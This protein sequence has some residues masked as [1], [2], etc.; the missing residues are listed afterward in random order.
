MLAELIELGYAA[1]NETGLY[2]PTLRMWELGTTTLADLPVKQVASDALAELHHRTGET[3]SL[4]VR[5]GDEALYIDKLISP[6]PMRFTTRVGSRVWLP[7]PAGGKAILAFSP[8]GDEVIERVAR[9][10]AAYD[11]DDVRRAMAH[12]R[13]HGYVSSS[14]RPGARSFA[15]PILDRARRPVGALSISAPTDRLQD[16]QADSIVD[17]V[18]A[19]ATRLSDS[20]GR[21]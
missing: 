9:D 2:E 5:D 1:Q 7:L 8:D 16:G 13:D 17:L 14:S 15:A 18:V 19:T 21:L 20:L 12:A 11:V 10:V 6:R 4:V 3:V